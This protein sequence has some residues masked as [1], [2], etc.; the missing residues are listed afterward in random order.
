VIVSSQGLL[1]GEPRREREIQERDSKERFKRDSR[2]RFKREIQE[3]VQERDPR[4]REDSRER[5]KRER[6]QERGGS[7][8]FIET[9]AS[10]KSHG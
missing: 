7:H 4:E 6:D 9:I 8:E 2:E 3:R 1:K 10:P 5:F